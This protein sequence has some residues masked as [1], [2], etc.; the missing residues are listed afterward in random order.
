[1]TIRKLERL[2]R[3]TEGKIRISIAVYGAPSN[4]F[5]SRTSL[6]FHLTLSLDRIYFFPE[7]SVATWPNLRCAIRRTSAHSKKHSFFNENDHQHIS[8]KSIKSQLRNGKF[9]LLQ[10]YYQQEHSAC[11][12]RSLN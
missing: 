2:I 12:L 4:K 9:P 3:R 5:H 10:M 11:I 6:R 8:R 7:H 1:M